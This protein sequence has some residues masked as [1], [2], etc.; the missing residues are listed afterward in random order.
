MLNLFERNDQKA[1]DLLASLKKADILAPTV[2]IEDDGFLPKDSESPF[3]YFADLK[4]SGRPRY[5][6]E[7]KVPRYYEISGTNDHALVSYYG[8]TKAV[9][10]YALPKEKRLVKAVS[11]LDLNGKV[12]CIDH[13]D[14]YGNRFAQ[15]VL[16]ESE[17]LILKTYFD[18]NGR[19]V[20]V[21][22]FITQD[23]ILEREHKI[24]TFNNLTEFIVFYLKERGFNLDKIY[25]N[26]LSYPFFVVT[27]LKAKGEDVL[28]WQEPLTNNIPGNMQVILD[29]K[30]P[31]VKKIVIQDEATYKT[32]LALTNDSPYFTK[33]G[34]IYAQKRSNRGRKQIFILTNSDQL[35]QIKPLIAQL[36][37]FKFHIA[38]LPEMST[39]LLALGQMQNVSLY[40]NASL[41]ELETLWQANDIYLDINHHQELLNAVRKAF[42]NEMLILAF[43]NTVH[44]KNF[45]ASENIYAP[46]EAKKLG[47]KL[48]KAFSEPHYLAELLTKQR[49]QA[50][51]ESK[52]SY[53]ERLG[54]K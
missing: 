5:F 37:D 7:I 54:F 47:E 33:L 26:S 19:E 45:I 32:A 44:D 4:K 16:D 30:V 17:K 24:T 36:P 12:R 29:E 13:Y 35:E 43:E 38:A 3:S 20:I 52:A 28:F 10:E 11:W 27:Q 49:K 51:T 14:Q 34:Y 31:R 1:L 40:Q 6:N 8:T 39:R 48:Q 9:I 15:S 42:E 25:F 18:R 46:S 53:R 21:Q 23:I 50:Q 41:K 22:N 2:F